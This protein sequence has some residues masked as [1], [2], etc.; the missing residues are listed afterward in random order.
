MLEGINEP[1]LDADD[2]LDAPQLSIDALVAELRAALDAPAPV[3][4]SVGVWE[5]RKSLPESLPE[6]GCAGAELR[7]ELVELA[8]SSCR[9]NANPGFFGFICAPGLP[10]DPLAHA[11]VAALNQNVASFTSAPGAAVLE[12][13]VL[14][15]FARLAGL[16]EQSGGA[17]VS[18]GSHGNFT[19]LACA[20]HR[21]AGPAAQEQG[22]GSFP[23][24]V[25]ASS[26]AHFSIERAL[27]VLGLGTRALRR[28]P[29]DTRFRL[30][31]NALEAMIA[32]DRAAGRRPAAIVASA[33]TTATGAIDPLPELGA[34]ARRH[35][36]WLHVD[37]AY[38]GAALLAPEL[39]DRLDGIEAADSVALDLHKWLYL[40]LD[41]GV[42]LLRDAAHSRAAFDFQSDYVPPQDLPAEE[43][44][45]LH[46]GLET[47]RRF[48][49]LPAYLALRNYGRRRLAANV[50]HNAE[51]ASY[52]ADLVRAEPSLELATEP[53]LSIV[54][55]RFAPGSVDAPSLDE[56][57]RRIRLE[58]ERD[59]RFYLSPLRVRGQFMLRVCLVSLATRA[60]HL[61]DLVGRVLELG[62]HALAR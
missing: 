28:V 54:C 49:A 14:R 11:A 43:P 35:G 33:G 18:G 40:A 4:P 31:L 36:L 29:V 30:D 6:N 52:L 5:A 62:E 56:L 51:L 34:A 1:E 50:R 10:T 60:S 48:R 53:E 38:G 59:G 2:E 9:R 12:S 25:Y 17:F 23:L 46:A 26:E 27:R 21:Q 44:T 3:R 41:S 45:F 55:F 37:A 13:R 16:P 58:L 57:N 15:W 7:A 24:T 32:E 20:L 61:R 22:L 39:R 8:R 19:A 47:S 42:V